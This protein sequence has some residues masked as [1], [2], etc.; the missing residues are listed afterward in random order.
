MSNE[1]SD[2]NLI[3]VPLYMISH[4]SPDAFKFFIWIL[5][6]YNDMF[7]CVSLSLSY[8]EFVELLGYV[9]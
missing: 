5:P 2:V 9:D 6:F 4:F 3:G 1:M 7:K 8:L